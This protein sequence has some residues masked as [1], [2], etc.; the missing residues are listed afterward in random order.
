MRTRICRILIFTM[1]EPFPVPTVTARPRTWLQ[2]Q[3][4]ACLGS[5]DGTWE[6]R[7]LFWLIKA[8]VIDEDDVYML[9]KLDWPLVSGSAA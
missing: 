3:R 9:G 4:G 2:I 8:K 6:S 1:R 7:Q 5:W